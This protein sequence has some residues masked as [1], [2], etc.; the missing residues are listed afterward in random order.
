[1]KRSLDRSCCCQGRFLWHSIFILIGVRRIV[2]GGMPT[3][4]RSLAVSDASRMPAGGPNCRMC[5]YQSPQ[6]PEL[7]SLLD[8]PASWQGTYRETRP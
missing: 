8:L 3:K 5:I 2:P 4:W 6:F 7:E 1:M